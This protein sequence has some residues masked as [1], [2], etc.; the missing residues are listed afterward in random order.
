VTH[1]R[2][3]TTHPVIKMWWLWA[4]FCSGLA[5]AMW[6]EDLLVS[7]REN[8]LQFSAPR[9]HFL[10]GKS[11]DRLHNAAEVPFD[12]RLTLWSGVRTRIFVNQA[13]RFVVSYDLWEEK[14]SV[15]K[16]SAPRKATAHLTAQAAEAWCL[17]QMPL[18]VAGLDANQPFWVRLEVRAQQ[19]RSG[20]TLFGREKLTEAGISLIGLV[21]IFSR[22]A[23]TD[24][25]NWTIDAGPFTMTEVRRGRV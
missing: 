4:A 16:L 2:R 20:G 3:A 8:Y 25:P 5:F 19:A 7:S 10:T 15:S 11:L 18:D 1:T 12:F 22:P 21:E 23:Q 14:F 13:E 9:L 17:E 6:A 24:Q